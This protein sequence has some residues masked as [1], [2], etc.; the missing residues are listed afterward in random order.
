MLGLGRVADAKVQLEGLSEQDRERADA[1]VITAKVA[2]AE[3]QPGD[4][5]SAIRPIAESDHANADVLALFGDALYAAG[6]STA[7]SGAYERALG[8]DTTHPE[9]L[10]GMAT[11]FVRSE[12]RREA[13]EALTRAEESMTT[14]IRGAALQARLLVVRGRALVEQ[15]ETEQARAALQQATTIPGAP[16]EAWFYL[17]EALSSANAVEARAA[18]QKYIELAPEGPLASRA[19]RA[20]R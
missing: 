13:L 15:R 4:A 1:R 19:R 12:K 3:G 17:G 16:A 6:E 2:L 18:Y 8:M 7:A 10:I 20:I 11:V 5:I 14:R 9:A